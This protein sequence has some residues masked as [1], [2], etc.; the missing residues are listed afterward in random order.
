MEQVATVQRKLFKEFERE[1]GQLGL[2]IS[3]AMTR[4]L[5][6]FRPENIKKMNLNKED[7]FIY[8]YEEE[9]SEDHE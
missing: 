1:I 3:N 4:A 6:Q 9:V 7:N 2:K 8:V 5:E